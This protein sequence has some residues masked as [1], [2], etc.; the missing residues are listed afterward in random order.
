MCQG[1]RRLSIIISHR[2]K[3]PACLGPKAGL[4]SKKSIVL[5]AGQSSDSLSENSHHSERIP[6]SHHPTC[7]RGNAGL[8]QSLPL[9]LAEIPPY[10]VC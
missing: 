3:A 10:A 5:W 7:P 1:V 4:R 2:R 9:S 8:A 6:P